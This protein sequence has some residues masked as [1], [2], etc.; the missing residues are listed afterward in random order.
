MTITISALNSALYFRLRSFNRSFEIPASK[1]TLSFL[2][3]VVV[4]WDGFGW[5]REDRG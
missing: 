4:V 3:I 2:E 5:E 1:E